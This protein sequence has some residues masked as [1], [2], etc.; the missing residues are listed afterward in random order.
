MT[1]YYAV[2]CTAQIVR[3]AFI[4]ADSKEQA[5]SLYTQGKYEI[6]EDEDTL[7]IDVISTKEEK[8]NG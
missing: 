7:N 1:K 2:K 5:L 3:V 4:K 8:Q 6:A